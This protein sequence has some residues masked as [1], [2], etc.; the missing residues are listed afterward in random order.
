MTRKQ[1]SLVSEK[2]HGENSNPPSYS[3]YEAESSSAPFAPIWAMLLGMLGV[4]IGFPNDLYHMPPLILLYP[5]ALLYLGEHARS[6]VEALRKGWLTGILGTFAA[7]YWIAIPIHNV[8]GLP[9]ALAVPCALAMGAYIGL[10]GGVFSYAAHKLQNTMPNAPL[11]RMLALACLWY[12]LELLRGTL[13]TGFPWLT[14]SAAFA[15]YPL[16][17]Q[18]AALIGSYALSAYYVCI[19]LLACV[20]F[21]ARKQRKTRAVA[22]FS[23]IALCSVVCIWGYIQLQSTQMAKEDTPFPVILVEG[24]IDQNIKWEAA[25]QQATLAT[26]MQLSN[27][28]LQ[29]MREVTPQAQPL[30]IWPETA[31]P[32]YI[33][34]HPK[35]G[36]RLVQ[37]V[38][39]AHTP[40]LVGAP[41]VNLDSKGL[42]RPFNRAY[43]IN[44]QGGLIQYYDKIHLVPFGEYVPEWLAWNFLEGLL[45][46]IGAFSVGQH[47]APLKNTQD[48]P[49]TGL[50]LGMLICYEGI[51]PE[52][53][54]ER[55]RQGANVLVNISN[56]GWFGDSSAPEQHLQLSLM[57]AV[58]QGR[59]L[60]RN[61]NTG[62]SALID[63][64]GRI[65]LR[66]AQFKAQSL[67]GEAQTRHNTTPFHAIY[68]YIPYTIIGIF[69]LCLGSYFLTRRYTNNS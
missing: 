31:M 37:F 15:P 36:R 44:E 50:A 67:S 11:R 23:C 4:W 64:H 19:T 52:L 6:G 41:A 40:L 45:Q 47:D 53:A 58:E 5:A 59:W 1:Y 12:G 9:W 60:I 69:F 29:K 54:Q 66:G 65:R 21:S 68:A 26:Y 8:G 20:A 61:T 39:D 30:I 46:S 38:R 57:R 7:L 63:A 32:F 14:L 22:G 62:I 42:N 56:D 10:Y 18:G 55:V 28:A 34:Q 3:P 24:N 48:A 35:L 27:T 2:A 33:E 17:I 13:L 25:L 16:F 49:P 51:F 43:F